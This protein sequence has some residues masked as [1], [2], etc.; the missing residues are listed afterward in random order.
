MPDLESSSVTSFQRDTADR[1][2]GIFAQDSVVVEWQAMRGEHGLYSP[3]V[4]I[5]VGPFAIGRGE[6]LTKEYDRLMSRQRRL[7]RALIGFHNTNIQHITN[8]NLVTLEHLKTANWNARC[9]LAIEIENKT[10]RKHLMG[11]AINAAALGR[12]GVGVAWN[13]VVLR[14]FTRMLA[15]LQFLKQV[16]KPTF[17][18]TNLLIADV[19]QLQS[20]LVQAVNE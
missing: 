18:T 4:D 11:S 14:S 10:T 13:Q 16:D 2:R 1:L 9:F 8:A 19:S 5:A 17:N 12:I 3:R 7:L 20:A 6:Q 15:Y